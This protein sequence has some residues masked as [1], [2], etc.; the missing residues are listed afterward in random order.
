MSDYERG[1][2]AAM[3]GGLADGL[4]HVAWVPF[5]EWMSDRIGRFLACQPE[6]WWCEEHEQAACKWD[7][8]GRSRCEPVFRGDIGPGSCRMVLARIVVTP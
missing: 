1:I 7:S 8:G 4:A 2:E 3:E 5:Q 6:V